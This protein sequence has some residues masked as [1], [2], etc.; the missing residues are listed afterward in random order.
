MNK[1]KQT[2]DLFKKSKENTLPRSGSGEAQ[3]KK[4]YTKNKENLELY[5]NEGIM[6]S[7]VASQG[8]PVLVFAD[9]SV[10]LGGGILLKRTVM[11]SQGVESA[12]CP[13]C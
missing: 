7:G 3:K 5:L 9:H 2:K 6:Y 13:Q 4:N 11:A 12:P 1:G 8:F 10:L